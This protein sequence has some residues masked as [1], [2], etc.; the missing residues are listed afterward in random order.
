MN[1]ILDNQPKLQM[2]KG[3][4]FIRFY[5]E[6]YTMY[7]HDDTV[8]IQVLDK[9]FM[10]AL[11]QYIELD[12]YSIYRV[13]FL[14][15]PFGEFNSLTDKRGLWDKNNTPQKILFQCQY[16][17]EHGKTYV[18]AYSCKDR[19]ND[20]GISLLVSNNY[21]IETQNIIQFLIDNK[22]EINNTKENRDI[23]CSL[24]RND[25][26]VLILYNYLD[27]CGIYNLLLQYGC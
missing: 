5:S 13:D 25:T 6:I 23:I 4:G 14:T 18:G 12:E 8:T 11:K 20:M 21:K 27:N 17:S 9:R 2:Q 1:I 19:L 10:E 15:L 16:I 22:F 7:E 3:D 26:N 24:K